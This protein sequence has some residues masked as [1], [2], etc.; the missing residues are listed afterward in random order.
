[1]PTGHSTTHDL[2]TEHLATEQPT[3]EGLARYPE[4]KGYYDGT[5]AEGY[6]DGIPCTCGAD[7]P[8]ICMKCSACSTAYYDSI[9]YD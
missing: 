5:E 1:M 6:L 9:E 2:A 8:H 4:T 3:A 7:C